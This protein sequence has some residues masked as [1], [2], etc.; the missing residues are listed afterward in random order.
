MAS[1]QHTV[2]FIVDKVSAAGVVSARKMFG[3]HAIYCD[4]MLVALICDDKLFVKPTKAG[5]AH[6]GNVTEAP[7]YKGAK[8]CLEI[9]RNKWGNRDW[10]VKL[11]RV[12]I[13]ELPAPPR[14][15]VTK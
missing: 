4:G 15:R 11:I 13:A 14:R 1:K 12:S 10:M 3:E 5:R 6:A 2:D 7:P 8:P 9:P